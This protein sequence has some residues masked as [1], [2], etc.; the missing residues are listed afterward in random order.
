MYYW[1][2]ECEDYYIYDDSEDIIYYHDPENNTCSRI[3]KTSG[4]AFLKLHPYMECYKT[5][6]KLQK[7]K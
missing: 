5:S 7:T 4:N 2:K 3:T 1:L 6:V